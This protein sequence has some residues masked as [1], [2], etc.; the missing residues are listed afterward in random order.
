V[1]LV[2]TSVWIDHLRDAV[3]AP[4]TYLRSLIS[5]QELPVGDLILCEIQQGLRTDAEARRVEA[6][7]REFE[8]VSLI[9][10]ELAAKAAATYR[11]LRRRGITIRKTIDLVIARSV[12]GAVTH[13]CTATVTSRR[14][15]AF[16]VCRPSNRAVRSRP[17]LRLSPE[18][19]TSRQGSR[20]AGVQSAADR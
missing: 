10:A 12:S 11:F 19:R 7:L 4:V 5:T 3:T 9:D 15:R 18:R 16:S 20:M 13:C 14:W 8:V 17:G 1:I 6:A 2:D